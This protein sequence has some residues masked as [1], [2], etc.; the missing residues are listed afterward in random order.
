MSRPPYHSRRTERRRGKRFPPPGAGPI[1]YF[2]ALSAL[3]ALIGIV[4][5]AHFR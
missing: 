1:L 5:E 2:L 4:V 3:A